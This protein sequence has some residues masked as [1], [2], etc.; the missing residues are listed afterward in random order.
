MILMSF[1]STFIRLY[2]SIII[3]IKKYLTKLLQKYNGAV[4]LPHS[5]LLK[6]SYNAIPYNAYFLLSFARNYLFL[7]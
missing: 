4:I 1:C 6:V 3:P 2:V 5:R 7:H